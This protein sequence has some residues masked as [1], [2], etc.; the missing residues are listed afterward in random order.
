MAVALSNSR[1]TPF[2]GMIFPSLRALLWSKAFCNEEH[3]EK[4][5]CK[6]NLYFKS[7]YQVK[8]TQATEAL[9]RLDRRLTVPS[10]AL[11]SSKEINFL[12]LRLHRE[13]NLACLH[14]SQASKQ[15]D[16]H[17]CS[18]HLEYIT[19]KKY[20]SYHTDIRI[21][22]QTFMEV[23]VRQDFVND[24]DI[25]FDRDVYYLGVCKFLI[26]ISIWTKG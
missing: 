17:N 24:S 10:E 15:L 9:G 22:F 5:R 4:H 21:S 25:D 6:C 13:S 1:S 16:Q 19:L 26:L 20:N 12:F 11:E 14:R 23:C 8:E 2:V 18:K 3:Q 7:V